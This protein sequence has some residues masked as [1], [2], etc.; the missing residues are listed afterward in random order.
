L[1]DILSGWGGQLS[2]GSLG[3][4][5]KSDVELYLTLSCRARRRRAAKILELLA[6]T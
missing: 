2:D 4:F 1:V 5:L 6:I 3:I